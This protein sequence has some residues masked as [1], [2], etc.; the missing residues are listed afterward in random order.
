[1][2]KKSY[3]TNLSFFLVFLGQNVLKQNTGIF[4]Y[5]IFFVVYWTKHLKAIGY[6]GLCFFVCRIKYV[7][8][9]HLTKMLLNSILAFVLFIGQLFFCI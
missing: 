2:T 8:A 5:S 7:K 1:M 4:F 3:Y 6:F 9:K